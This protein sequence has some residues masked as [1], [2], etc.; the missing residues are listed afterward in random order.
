MEQV[1]QPLLGGLQQHRQQVAGDA[2]VRQVQPQFGEDSFAGSEGRFGQLTAGGHILQ[3]FAQVHWHRV[4]RGTP[5]PCLA[6]V[7]GAGR[8]ALQ[9]DEAQQGQVVQ[10]PAHLAQPHLVGGQQQHGIRTGLLGQP[11][12]PLGEGGA[13]GGVPHADHGQG[14]AA[15]Q[16]DAGVQGAVPAPPE[17]KG[18]LG[19]GKGSNG[20]VDDGQGVQPLQQDS[21]PAGGD[22]PGG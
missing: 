7:S 18:T 14:L 11:P 13:V 12:Q 2:L 9:G 16:G 21:L 8:V 19:L 5:D 15:G 3:D 17:T 22:G 4:A 20:A 6:A 1:Q 10:H